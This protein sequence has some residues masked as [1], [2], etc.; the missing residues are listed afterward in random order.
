MPSHE[1]WR[2]L[3]RSDDLYQSRIVATCLDAMEFETRLIDSRGRPIEGGE[4][5]LHEPAFV[6]HVP[7]RDWAILNDVLSEL[8]EEQVQ[9]DHALLDWRCNAARRERHWMALLI[10]IVIVLAMFGLIKL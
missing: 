5:H 7:D 2:E 4:D 3:Y 10:A 6:I 8:I 9:F 1:S